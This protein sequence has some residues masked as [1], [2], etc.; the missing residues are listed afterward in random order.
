MP[1]AKPKRVCGP[2]GPRNRWTTEQR[3][4]LRILYEN[5]NL[6]NA[7]RVKAFNHLFRDHQ[8][9]CGVL[10]GLTHGVLSAQWAERNMPKKTCWRE[11]IADPTTEQGRQAISDLVRRIQTIISD[12]QSAVQSSTVARSATAARAASPPVPITARVPT[13]PLLNTPSPTA[14]EASTPST[15]PR[16]RPAT[17]RSSVYTYKRSNKRSRLETPAPTRSPYDSDSHTSTVLSVDVPGS[18]TPVAPVQNPANS[19]AP[20][21]ATPQTAELARSSST[22]SAEQQLRVRRNGPPLNLSPKAMEK[23]CRPLLPVPETLAHPPISGL[24]FRYWDENSAGLNSEDGF[25]AGRFMYNNVPPRPPPRCG[26]LDYADMENHFNRNK[27]ASPFCT[28]E[29]VVW[30]EIPKRAM[31][32][33]FSVAELYAACQRMPAMAAALSLDIVG[34]EG[35]NLKKTVLIELELRGIALSERTTV[36]LAEIC[37][38]VGLTATSSLQHLEHIVSDIVQGWRLAIQPSTSAEWAMLAS[39]FTLKLCN[40]DRSSLDRQMALQMCY[41]SGV[42]AG[43]GEFNFMLQ[44][45]LIAKMKRKS[46]IVG[47]ES[48]TQIVLEAIANATSSVLDY[49]KEQNKRY[50]EA[51]SRIL[52]PDVEDHFRLDSDVSSPSTGRSRGLSMPEDDEIM[53]DDDVLGT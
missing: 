13:T 7:L 36:I 5:F 6:D 9:A 20:S 25:V 11:A 39:T 24:M 23:A 44:P 27:I 47:L 30:H 28:H 21:H 2:R 51:E 8:R 52:L 37:H 14:G 53:Y 19:V 17:K 38:F 46:I 50:A 15:G 45:K 12:I 48:P 41:L 42:K 4:A 35:S 40:Q 29:F 34:K 26:E 10:H 16:W 22:Y 32:N 18:V 31:I 49:D 1:A 3:L 43:L 33:T